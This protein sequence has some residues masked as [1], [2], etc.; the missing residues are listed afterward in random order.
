M[1]PIAVI[2]IECRFPGDVTSGEN[3]WD[4]LVEK[5]FARSRVPS[6]LYNFDPFYHPDEDRYGTTNND[7]GHFVTE[8]ISLFDASFFSIAPAE[9]MAMDSMQRLL[10]E[11][12]YEALENSGTP[13]F[14]E[15][16]RRDMELAPRYQST[17][18]SQT[19]LSNR[20]SY[21]FDMKRPRITLD[22]ACSS[23]LVTVHLAC[24]SLRTGESSMAVVGGSNLILSPDI[25]IEMSDMHFLSPD[26][27]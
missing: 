2:G 4:K 16:Q 6:D 13:L 24:Q 8:D 27:I 21:F 11:V 1:T 7:G 26:S 12:T 18:V 15:M 9:A 25:Q 3:L 22:T 23:G 5:N 17:S 19:M 10:L 14:R 20:L